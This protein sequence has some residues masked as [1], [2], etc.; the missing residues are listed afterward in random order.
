MKN[1]LFAAALAAGCAH[2]PD[3]R[4]RNPLT[5]RA[6]DPH[7][8]VHPHDWA[9]QHHGLPP[10]SM[11]DEVLMASADPNQICFGLA[12]HEL[13][14]IDLSGVDARLTVPNMSPL[15]TPTVQAE[16]PTYQTFQGL[17]PE[18]R[19]TGSETFC[20]NYDRYNNCIRWQTRPTYTTVMVPG[21]VNVYLTRG[22][23][24]FPNGGLLT[25]ATPQITL[26][27]KVPITGQV[28][29]F[30]RP[31]K[32]QIFGWAFYGGAAPPTATK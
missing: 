16:P 6:V 26:D 10:G 18:T 9:E 13:A 4:I 29:L 3:V 14:A 1:V 25:E 2:E 5:A 31:N 19:P 8:I 12:L 32:R 22:M 24:C 21:P 7:R 20:A 27:L 23:L 17:V 28:G 15:E 30:G 11:N